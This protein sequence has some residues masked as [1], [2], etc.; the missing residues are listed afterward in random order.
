VNHLPVPVEVSSCHWLA[1]LYS[2]FESPK[3]T[4]LGTQEHPISYNR[5][6]YYS[7]YLIEVSCK[8]LAVDNDNDVL[9]IK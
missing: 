3:G 8:I 1:V 6:Q 5:N 7:L 9:T 2:I 4:D